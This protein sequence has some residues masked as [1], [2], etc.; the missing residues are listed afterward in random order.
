MKEQRGGFYYKFNRE[1]L[2]WWR[3]IPPEKKLEW[4]EEANVFLQ[5]ALTKE[6][7]QIMEAFRK[8]KVRINVDIRE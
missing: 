7:R 5:K 4:L 6:R 8:G 2:S 3:A 1:K